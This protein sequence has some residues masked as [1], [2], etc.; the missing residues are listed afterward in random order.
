MS[1][2]DE[3]GGLVFSQIGEGMREWL[4]RAIEEEEVRET[5][6]RCT[7]TRLRDRM[8]SLKLFFSNTVGV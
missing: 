8:N 4:E 1:S 7:G 6:T 3:I 2:G 5:V